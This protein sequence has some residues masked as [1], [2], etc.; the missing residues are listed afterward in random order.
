MTPL[1]TIFDEAWLTTNPRQFFF[2]KEYFNSE[3]DADNCTIQI[4]FKFWVYL[5]RAGYTPFCRILC[6][7]PRSKLLFFPT[8]N[9]T[10]I[11]GLFNKQILG[12]VF[13]FLRRIPLDLHLNFLKT[14]TSAYFTC[15]QRRSLKCQHQRS[16]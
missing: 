2:G 6:T 5:K 10:G 3:F 14:C 1:M 8:I 12:F 15:S 13:R 11:C 9:C 4:I 16:L 7:L